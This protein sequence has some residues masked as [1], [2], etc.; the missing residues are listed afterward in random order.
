[1]IIVD[2]KNEKNLETA[3][4]TYKSKIH[5]VKQIQKLREREEFVNLQ[6]RKE[7]KNLK[8]FM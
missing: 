3:L 4:R 7:R 5:K 2:L 6:L 8:Q 1:M